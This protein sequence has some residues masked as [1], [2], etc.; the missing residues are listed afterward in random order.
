MRHA[1]ND[2][3]EAREAAD[4]GCNYQLGCRVKETVAARGGDTHISTQPWVAGE[5]SEITGRVPLIEGI[6][7]AEAGMDQNGKSSLSESQIFSCYFRIAFSAS[8]SHNVVV[9]SF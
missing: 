1:L 9:V 5:L 8:F 7:W 2:R 4:N 6:G 3:L